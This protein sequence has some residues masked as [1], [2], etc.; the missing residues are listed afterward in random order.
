MSVVSLLL[1]VPAGI[2]GELLFKVQPERPREPRC[3]GPGS[4]VPIQEFLVALSEEEISGERWAP[5]LLAHGY[6]GIPRVV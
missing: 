3:K 1:R 5:M 4:W 2:S 6:S